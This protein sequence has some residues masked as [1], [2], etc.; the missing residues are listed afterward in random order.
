MNIKLHQSYKY[1]I[2]VVNKTII[3]PKYV[4]KTCKEFINIADGKSRKYVIDLE[5]LKK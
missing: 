5:T 4:V 2:G 3:A 1:A